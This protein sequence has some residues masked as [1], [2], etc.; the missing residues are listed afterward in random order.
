MRVGSPHPLLSARTPSLTKEV[1]PSHQNCRAYH[2]SLGSS[3]SGIPS[4]SPSD[5]ISYIV[6]QYIY[7]VR[8]PI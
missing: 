5:K 1:V 7:K 3:N 4:K 2:A 8:N 6:P